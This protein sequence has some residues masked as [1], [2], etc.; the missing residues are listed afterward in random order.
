MRIDIF[1][2]QT[3]R[4]ELQFIQENLMIQSLFPDYTKSYRQG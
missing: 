2:K 1:T 3:S 4:S